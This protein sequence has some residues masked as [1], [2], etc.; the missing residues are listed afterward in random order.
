MRRHTSG[1]G[2]SHAWKA[3]DPTAILPALSGHLP[4][5]AVPTHA[6]PGQA[7]ELSGGGGQC[8]GC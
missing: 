1:E 6:E 3:G 7:T 5:L 4:Q 2:Q 8:G